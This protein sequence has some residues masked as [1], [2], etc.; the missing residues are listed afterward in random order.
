VDTY[1]QE[2]TTEIETLTR[3]NKLA[4]Q[5]VYSATPNLQKWQ[6]DDEEHLKK[7]ENHCSA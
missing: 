5:E 1:I 2:V 4:L 3:T 7:V 6:D